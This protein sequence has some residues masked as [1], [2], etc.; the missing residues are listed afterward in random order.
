MVKLPRDL[1][2]IGEEAFAGCSSLTG[3]I[4]GGDRLQKIGKRAFMGCTALGTD[5]AVTDGDGNE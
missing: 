3:G 4:Q 2:E 5:E 1:R